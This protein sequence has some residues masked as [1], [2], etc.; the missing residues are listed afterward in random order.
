MKTIEQ[1]GIFSIGTVI[2]VSF[3]YYQILEKVKSFKKEESKF[4]LVLLYLS[5]KFIGFLLLGL[6]PALLAFMIFDFQ[7]WQEKILLPGSGNWWVWMPVASVLLVILNLNNSKSE[8][9]RTFY[10]E[11]RLKQWTPD[12]LAI[13]SAGWAIY[14]AGYEY[15][16]RGILLSGCITAF[17][18]WPA[19]VINLAL[20]SSLHLFKGLKEAAAAIP[21]GAFLCYITLESQSVLP[22]ILIH[23]IQAISCEIAC[24]YRNKEMSF[25]FNKNKTS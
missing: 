6:I 9:L 20:Y 3:L 2:I 14:L 7:P 5:A 16:F 24:I 10:P 8:E 18:V 17:G 13:T 15:L 12:S 11:L 19:I 22:A 1:I 4:D 21:F 25:S 23:S